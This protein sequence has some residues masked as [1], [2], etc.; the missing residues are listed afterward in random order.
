MSYCP[1]G[2]QQR[3]LHRFNE[4][5]THL[6]ASSM[7]TTRQ[8]Q[9]GGSQG[10]KSIPRMASIISTNLLLFFISNKQ[11]P[12]PVWSHRQSVSVLSVLV[13]GVRAMTSRVLPFRVLGAYLPLMIAVLYLCTYRVYSLYGPYSISRG[14][15]LQK[16]ARH[17]NR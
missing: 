17:P 8:K 11:G 2:N 13:I 15:H 5:R 10:G 6:L 16:A 14:C 3:V 9:S 1:A 7:P 12:F 4:A